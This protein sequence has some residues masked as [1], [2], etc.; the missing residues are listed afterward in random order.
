MT[1]LTHLDAFSHLKIIMDIPKSSFI[2]E[3]NP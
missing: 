3:K 2:W 1:L